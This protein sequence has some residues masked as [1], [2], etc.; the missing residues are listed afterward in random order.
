MADTDNSRSNLSDAHV[1][2]LAIPGIGDCAVG[3][4]TAELNSVLAKRSSQLTVVEIN[5][6][7]VVPHSLYNDKVAGL[8][9]S[10]KQVHRL[11]T[12]LSR[13]ARIELSPDYP[14]SRLG[15]WFWDLHLMILSFARTL[16]PLLAI[17]AIFGFVLNFNESWS[18]RKTLMT[19]EVHGA[20]ALLLL[21]FYALLSGGL[22]GV[23]SR[24]TS[25]G[26]VATKNTIL[27]LL[28]PAIGIAVMPFLLAN[29]PLI[30]WMGFGFVSLS[31]LMG[32]QTMAVN[33]FVDIWII[34]RYPIILTGFGLVLVVMLRYFMGPVVKAMLDI[35]NY[36]GDPDYRESL[37]TFLFDE[38]SADGISLSGA[39]VI[40]SAH[41]LGTVI[42]VDSLLRSDLWK[43]VKSLTLL[44][45]GSPLRRFFIRLFPAYIFP[46]S[47]DVVYRQLTVRVPRFRWINTYRMW[48]YVGTRLHLP[49]AV[50]TCEIRMLQWW[51]LRSSHLNYWSDEAIYRKV[52][53]TL[54]DMRVCW[55]AE[56][57]AHQDG[58]CTLRSVSSAKAWVGAGY[59]VGGAVFAIVAVLMC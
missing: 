9:L 57:P 22:A 15:R 47:I 46:T 13:L 41:S 26:W 3:S 12:M 31:L 56:D 24:S 39:D 58:G 30:V 11:F 38:L 40:I 28:R 18:H 44:T 32:L 17:L 1:Y 55:L 50:N 4:L 21:G 29:W 45:G 10:F 14:H 52:S 51:K 20:E 53:A 42:A 25:P 34:V 37:R 7:K 33:H 35:V 54:A 23:A 8:I 43:D 5:W 27:T 49:R 59:I 36:I 16:M 19:I 48:D 2:L 6:H